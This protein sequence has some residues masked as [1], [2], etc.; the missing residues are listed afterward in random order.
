MNLTKIPRKRRRAR[1][2]AFGRR[3]RRPRSRLDP[4]GACPVI[5]REDSKPLTG[6]EGVRWRLVAETDDHAE[7]PGR[8]VAAAAP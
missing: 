2:Y 8:R 1:R 5:L 7:A 4:A 3:L 6:G